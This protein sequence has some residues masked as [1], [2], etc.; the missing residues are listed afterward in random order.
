MKQHLIFTSYILS[1]IASSVVYAPSRGSDDRN[2]FQEAVYSKVN[3][4]HSSIPVL[5]LIV[6]S[7]ERVIRFAKRSG[8][9]SRTVA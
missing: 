2:S 1:G 6:S 7:Q 3:S 4:S 8:V 9:V 5:I